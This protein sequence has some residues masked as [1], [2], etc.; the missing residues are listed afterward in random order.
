MIPQAAG[1]GV[2]V[3]VAPIGP[4]S[5][6]ALRQAE[7]SDRMTVVCVRAVPTPTNSSRRRRCS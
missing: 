5:A 1:L 3:L 6:V 4:S 7:A 2:D